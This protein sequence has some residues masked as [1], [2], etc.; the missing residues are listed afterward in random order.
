[1]PGGNLLYLAVMGLEVD[2]EVLEG[3]G[4]AP[5]I[6]VQR[7]LPYSNAADPVLDVALAE[8]AKRASKATSAAGTLAK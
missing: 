4:V 5:D 3:Q 8:L 7:P 2:G 6:A 1:M